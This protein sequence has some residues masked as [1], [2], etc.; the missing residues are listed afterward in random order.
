MTTDDERPP[1]KPSRPTD[2]PPEPKRDEEERL[3][4]AGLALMIPSLMVAGPLLGF[5]LGRWFGGMAGPADGGSLI[6]LALGL[7]AGIREV[8]KILRRMSK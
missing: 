7:A 5:L 3:R 1:N 8:I 6:G 4:S 2:G